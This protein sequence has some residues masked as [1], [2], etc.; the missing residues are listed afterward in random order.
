[1]SKNQEKTQILETGPEV[2]QITDLEGKDFKHC[3]AEYI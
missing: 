2:I 1:M 3:H